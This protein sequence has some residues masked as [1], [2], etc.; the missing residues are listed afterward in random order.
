MGQCYSVY[1][2][3]NFKNDDATSFCEAVKKSVEGLSDWANF[4]DYDDS[5][6]DTP[7]GCFQIIATKRGSFIADN[8]EFVSDFDAS[9]GWEGVMQDIFNEVMQVLDNG[10]RVMIYPDHGWE[11]WT[12][13]NGKVKYT[14]RD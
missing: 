10:S 6:F 4:G 13:R 8:G 5:D 14:Y 11:R 12:V 7:F 2:K 1:A 9:Y 3:L